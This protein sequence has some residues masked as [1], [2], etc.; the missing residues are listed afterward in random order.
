MDKKERIK[1]TGMIL[2][3]DE[4]EKV[5]GGEQDH[6]DDGNTVNASEGGTQD[7]INIHA[8]PYDLPSR[9]D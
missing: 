2:T 3:D 4:L 6:L 7:G 9:K 1:Q 5:A 8:N